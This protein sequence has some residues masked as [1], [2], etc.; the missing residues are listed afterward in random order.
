MP[1]EDW[2]DRVEY[3]EESGNTVL[4]CIVAGFIIGYILKYIFAKCKDRLPFRI[5]EPGTQDLEA[6]VSNAMVQDQTVVDPA[7]EGRNRY[8]SRTHE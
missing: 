3:E 5:V 2:R 6:S 4:Y 1:E 7:N 8:A